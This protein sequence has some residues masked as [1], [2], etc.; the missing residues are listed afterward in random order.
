MSAQRAGRSAEQEQFAASLHDMLAA[1]DVPGAARR[2]AAGDRAAAWRCGASSPAPGVT[3]LAVPEKLGRARRQ[4]AGHRGRLR[5]TRAPCA[6]GAGSRVGGRGS[7]ADRR[8]GRWRRPARRSAMAAPPG[9]RGPD[10]DAGP[11]AAAAVRGGRRRSGPGPAGRDRYQ[12]DTHPLARRAGRPAPVGGPGPVAVR[13]QPARGA[14]P[15]P[16][17]GRRR[18]PGVPGRRAG[19]RGAAAR[20]GPRPAG[21]QRAARRAADP[22]R[23]AGR[24][25]PGRQ[26][27]PGRRGDRARVRPP[28]ARRALPSRWRPAI[29][30]AARDVSA[31]KVACTDAARRAA[32]AGAAGARRD[33]LH[34][35]ARPAPVADE[36]RARWPGP[37]AARP[38]TGRAVMAA[39]HRRRMPRHGAD[40]RAAGPARRGPRAAGPPAGPAP[41]PGET[42]QARATTGRCGSGCAARSASLAWPSR[43]AT[44][45]PAPARPRPT[46]SW[47]NS[48]AA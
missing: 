44:A 36:G 37:G 32:R 31:A 35:G 47:R 16:G 3:A 23:P 43:S 8:A 45:A 24:G 1:A 14:G 17:R 46:S 27:P 30:G 4:P 2:W 12:R 15:W 7:G 10:R 18:H 40:R 26:A 28:A 5:G 19:Q 38:N 6:A 22:V 41:Q 33:R 42:G 48:A 39:T 25:V 21:G 29:R 13:G 9:R 11:A 34:R 20:R